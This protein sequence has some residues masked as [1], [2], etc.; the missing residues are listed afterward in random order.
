MDVDEDDEVDADG[1][2]DDD[3]EI[4]EADSS[5]NSGIKPTTKIEVLSPNSQF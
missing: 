4:G 1:E 2:R 3:D 5:N